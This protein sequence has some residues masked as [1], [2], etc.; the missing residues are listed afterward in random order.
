MIFI[1]KNNIIWH[2]FLHN[3]I[4]MHIPQKNAIINTYRLQ[5]K[6]KYAIDLL[7]YSYM[8]DKLI[9]CVKPIM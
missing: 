6:I 9:K 8:K 2:E 5:R 3:Y 1:Y 7:T 4:N